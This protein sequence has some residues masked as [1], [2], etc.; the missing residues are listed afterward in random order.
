MYVIVAPI[1]IKPEHKEAFIE[2][3][4]D[5]AVGS[6]S[7][8][9]GCLRFNVIQDRENPNK[10]YLFEVYKDKAAFD[11]HLQTP[12]FIKW[13][14]TVKDWFAEPVKGARGTNIFPTDADWHKDWKK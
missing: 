7:N 10:I 8:E 6:V 1:K 5:D 12:H 9:P 3:M 2:S 13:R 14:D 11:A 4:L